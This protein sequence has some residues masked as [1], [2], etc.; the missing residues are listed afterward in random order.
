MG[1]DWGFSAN[2]TVYQPSHVNHFQTHGCA[3][4]LSSDGNTPYGSPR[5]AASHPWS[6]R[7]SSRLERSATPMHRGV[8][9]WIVHG[10]RR[11]ARPHLRGGRGCAAPPL[12]TRGPMRTSSASV[13]ID[14]SQRAFPTPREAPAIASRQTGILVKL[15]RSR[16]NATDSIASNRKHPRSVSSNRKHPRSVSSNRKHPRSVSPRTCAGASGATGAPL[17]ATTMRAAGR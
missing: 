12:G 16:S 1:G 4:R 14:P 15:S 8:E 13:A 17:T 2:L 11:C 5:T 3:L 6:R 7:G 10:C 9:W